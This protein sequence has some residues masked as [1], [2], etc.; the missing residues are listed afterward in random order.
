MRTKFR[1]GRQ[2][3]HQI[4][5]MKEVMRMTVFVVLEVS[6]GRVNQI[7]V[8]LSSETA[9][10]TKNK[11]AKVGCKQNHPKSNVLSAILIRECV[12]KP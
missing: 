8:H 1:S 10:E 5:I 6:T 12:I 4:K 2:E 7:Q 9:R 11:W 3:A